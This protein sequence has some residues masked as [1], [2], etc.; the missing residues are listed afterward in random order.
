MRF[1]GV[2]Y[3]SIQEI[4]YPKL[5]TGKKAVVT[6]ATSGIGLAIARKFVTMG[7]EV[8]LV[9]RNVNSLQKLKKEFL[10]R[11]DK[12]STYVWDISNVKAVS[13]HIKN[14]KSE[15]GGLDIWVNNAGVY[16]DSEN[17]FSESEWDVVMDT[18][19]RS[20]YFI[21]EDLTKAMQGAKGEVSKIIN[22]TSNR[23]IFA[24][25]GPYG[26]AKV[27]AIS[28][29]KGFAKKYADK[30]LVI[31]SIAPG[32]T[33]TNINHI[34]ITGNVYVN[35]G[36]NYR[37]SFPQEIAEI[38]AFLASGAA[39]HIVGQTIVCDGGQTILSI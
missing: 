12:V 30:G 29:T 34:D 17:G 33:A 31:N 3:T 14:I 38:A 9:G 25:R 20:L 4:K 1:G 10:A 28:L 32:I 19:C 21:M 6:G 22:I 23:G 15:L 24:D 2:V 16:I 18:D 13:N 37:V 5:L 39:N 11:G 8:C 36:A 26:A 27:A 35:E 7:A